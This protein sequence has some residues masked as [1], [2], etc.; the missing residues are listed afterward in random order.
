M[1]QLKGEQASK[2]LYNARFRARAAAA[3]ACRATFLP[4]R[5]SAKFFVVVLIF[6]AYERLR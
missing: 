2:R 6:V 1:R 5:V 4:T 3:A